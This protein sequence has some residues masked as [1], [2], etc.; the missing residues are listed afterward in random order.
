MKRLVYW[1]LLFSTSAVAQ[2]WNITEMA[3]MPKRISNNA[4]C[5]GTVS[6]VPFVFSFGGIDSTKIYSGITL[7]SFR[8]NT[9]TDV[10]EQIPDLP[11]ASGK[12]ASAASN[13]KNRIYIIG[14]YHVLSNGSEIS[15][16]KV[17]IYDPETNAFLPDAMNIPVPIDDQVQG[18][19]R[20]SLI[21]VITGWSNSTNV[22][23]V[24]IFNPQS[25]AWSAG[26]P[27]PNTSIYKVFGG[28]GLIIG[29]TIFY[30]GGAS[31][32]INFPAQNRLRMGIIDPLNPTSITWSAP[33]IYQ[34]CYRCAATSDNGNNIYFLGGSAVSY[35]YNGVA[36]NGTGGVS[37]N[38][39]YAYLKASDPTNWN[40]LNGTLPMDLRGIANTSPAVKYIVGGMET[41]QLVSNKTL[42][43]QLSG[44]VGLN[45]IN[46][47]GVN[48]SIYPNP[49]TGQFT[50]ELKNDNAEVT[51]FDAFGQQ[52]INAQVAQEVRRFQLEKNG[53]YYIYIK[54]ALSS[55]VRKIVVT[56]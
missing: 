9:A 29:D 12:I 42:K 7:N 11:D 21:Y 33:S 34:N 8:Y 17:H 38:T 48:V 1:L 15:S 39:S 28:A 14:G 5:E 52:I 30:Y 32:G 50:L 41:N 13:I 36:Y 40:S 31:T 49:T 27:V 35:N 24:Q 16:N 47:K 6:D 54:T 55:T 23:N 22:P 53:I 20:D 2:Q 44:I 19:W 51:I 18:V 37:P 43:L 46:R 45:E 3:P 25:N 26:T 10:W 4:V 56:R